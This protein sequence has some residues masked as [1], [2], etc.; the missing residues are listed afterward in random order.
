MSKRVANCRGKTTARFGKVWIGW[1]KHRMLS[2]LEKGYERDEAGKLDEIAKQKLAHY[3]TKVKRLI[4]K[5]FLRRYQI[6]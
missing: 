1:K 5:Q 6:R 2:A 4:P 3:A